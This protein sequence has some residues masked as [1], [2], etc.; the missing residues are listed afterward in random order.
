MKTNFNA[1]WGV[2]YFYLPTGRWYAMRLYDSMSEAV[3]DFIKLMQSREI[4]AV[5]LYEPRR[6][7]YDLDE[8]LW[9]D[10]K[11]SRSARQVAAA[12]A[13][14]SNLENIS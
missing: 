6:G 8:Y 14:L 2:R 12:I 13:T 10:E 4:A 1:M 11:M 3:D 5:R 9:H 7:R